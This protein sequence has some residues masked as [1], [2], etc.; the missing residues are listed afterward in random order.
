[1]S[2]RIIVR[3]S[4]CKALIKAPPQLRGQRRRCPGCQTTI[5]LQDS[6]PPDSDPVLVTP[7]WMK[8]LQTT[9]PA[10]R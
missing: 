1:M 9:A 4:G 2:Y 3:C 5:L 7:D 10:P 6:S 8:S